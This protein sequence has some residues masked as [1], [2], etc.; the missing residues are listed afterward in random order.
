MNAPEGFD[1]TAV[2]EWRDWEEHQYLPGYYTGGR[3]PG[4]YLRP[5]TKGFAA[6]QIAVASVFGLGLIAA[7]AASAYGGSFQLPIVVV[8]VVATVVVLAAGCL[9]WSR[10]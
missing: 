9:V 8:A 6:I 2:E 10:R 3:V 4:W 7:L 5:W 1:D